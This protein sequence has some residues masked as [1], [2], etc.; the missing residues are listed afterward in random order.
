[1]QSEPLFPIPSTWQVSTLG[2][3]CSQG[4]GY[5]QTGPFGSQLHAKDYV[6]LGIPVI[7]PVNLGNNIIIEEGIE[8]VS[9]VDALRLAKHRLNPGNI[10]FSRRG[11]LERRSIVREKHTGW[12]CGTGCL[13]VDL[14]G[15]VVDPSFAS[16]YLA[17]P[18]VTNWI[19]GHAVG[20]TMPNINTEILSEVP[21]VL[22]P[23]WEQ[24]AIATI[25]ATLDDKIELNRQ[26][27]R[28][29]E[30]MAQSIFKSWFVDFD[31]VVARAAGKQPYGMD[32]E[33]AS[34]FPSSFY[35]SPVGNIPESWRLVRV[36]EAIELKY[37]KSLTESQRNPGT[38]AVFGSDGRIGWHDNALV[39]GPGI[40][41]GRKGNAGKVNWSEINFYPIDTTFYVDPKIDL[42]FQFLFHSL[43]TIDFNSISGDSAVPGLNREIAYS[44]EFVVP[45]L[46]ITT[47]FERIA[48]PINESIHANNVHSTTLEAVRDFLLPKLLSGEIRMCDAEKIAEKAL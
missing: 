24:Q 18:D 25:L 47:C 12:L 33:T 48:R 7:M 23:F 20:T 44:A 15:G 10:V 35:D 37:G 41:I 3:V 34:L 30:S 19:K 39:A 27:N 14:G 46:T 45:P 5:V 13:K 31:P 11:D 43:R 21:F 42:G 17:H 2:K 4:G 9:E 6:P 16:Y 38:V 40:I 32:A 36:G 28:T 22:P 26:M 29:L 8:R 1:M